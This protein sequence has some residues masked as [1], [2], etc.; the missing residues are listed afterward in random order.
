MIRIKAKNF[1]TFKSLMF[2]INMSLEYNVRAV[3][4]SVH[5]LQVR[6]IIIVLHYFQL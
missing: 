4:F 6:S 1:D 5:N 3:L 2:Y